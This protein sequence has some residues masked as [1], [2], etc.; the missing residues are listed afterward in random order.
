MR[1]G[2]GFDVHAFADQRALI[3][4]GVKIPY[5]RGLLGH[6]DADVLVHSIMDALLGAMALGDI[7][8]HF[9]DTDPAYKDIN[10]LLLL[11][12]VIALLE[13]HAYR[14]GNID[15]VISAQEPKLAPYIPKMKGILSKHLKISTGQISIKATTT[16]RLGYEG[17]KEGITSQCVCLIESRK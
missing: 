8:Q 11:D 17:R 16:E 6:S 1:I 7:G 13:K 2:F 3:L 5:D 15:C 14:I 10:S 4:G 12:K 9:P